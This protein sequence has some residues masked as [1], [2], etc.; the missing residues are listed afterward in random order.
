MKH[1]L[2]VCSVLLLGLFWSQTLNA[3]QIWIESH[4]QAGK[5][6]I[7][8]GF[9]HGSRWDAHLNDRIQQTEYFSVAPKG[10]PEPFQLSVQQEVYQTTIPAEGP[11]ELFG[12]CHYGYVDS[13]GPQPFDLHYYAKRLHAAPSQWSKFAP[14]KQLVVEIVP[15]MSGDELV[16]SVFHE[17]KPL[18]AAKLAF[19]SSF[20]EEAE[21]LETDDRGRVTINNLKSG[22]YYFYVMHKI[23]G[24]GTIGEKKFDFTYRIGT[25]SL[26]L[27]QADLGTK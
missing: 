17:G 2:H 14:R 27:S 8:A 10:E 15:Q 19:A 16:L 3:H 24:A 5:L 4:E 25:L 23:P 7:T 12:I 20:S 26:T 22:D 6:K 11:V 13:K 9:G 18:P 1:V 21:N